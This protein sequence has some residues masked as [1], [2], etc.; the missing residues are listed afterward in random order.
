MSDNSRS[1]PRKRKAPIEMTPDEF[2]AAGHKLVDD[3]AEFLQALGDRPVSRDEQ[4]SD[5]HKLLPEKLPE[6][7]T[8]PAELLRDFVPQFF[9]HSTFNGH[10][11]FY[12]YITSSAAPIGA[13][14]DMLA[15]AVNPN[16]GGWQLSP[17]ASEIEKQCVE[18]IAELIGFPKGGSGVFVSGGNVANFLCFLAARQA[19]APANLRAGGITEAGGR[20]LVYATSETHTWIQKATDIFGHGTDTM[21]TIPLD[22]DLHADITSLGEQ[23]EADRRQGDHPFLIVG[24]GGTVGTGAID[25]LP[26]LAAIARKHDLWFHVDGAYGALAAI[27]PDCPPELRGLELADSVAVD[28]HKW[29][30]SPLEAGCVLVRDKDAL[31]NAFSYT[32]PYY[33]FEEE[34]E[35]KINYYE[36]GLQNSRG[37]R[38]LKTWLAIRQVGRSGYIEMIE[39]DIALSKAMYDAADDDPELEA[40]TQSLSITTFRYVPQDLTPGSAPVEKYLNDLNEEILVRLK[41]TGESF[42]TNAVIGEMFVLRGC[43]V[44][45]RTSLDD[46]AALPDIVKRHGAD[47]DKVM[48]PAELS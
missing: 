38:A 37:F 13:L 44:N 7:G 30:Y 1:A 14:A 23:I 45:F 20:M 33:H 10:P 5:I 24:T 2:R 3:I 47:A 35:P 15:A 18:W 6:K 46:I 22:K 9:D 39:D 25:P 32:P 19:K 16:L 11:R 42:L 31:V 4:P 17:I 40:V 36:Y 28:P 8:D 48:R 27:L 26:D 29:L 12:G 43:I 41:H 21:R 34:E